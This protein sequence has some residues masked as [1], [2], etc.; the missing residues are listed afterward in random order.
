MLKFSI[1]IKHFLCLC[2]FLVTNC[3]LPQVLGNVQLNVSMDVHVVDDVIY[4]QCVEGWEP[5]HVMSSI[6]ASNGTWQPNPEELECQR[7]EYRGKGFFLLLIPR[8]KTILAMIISL[9]SID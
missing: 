5:A 3:S 1:E 8:T 7:E 4:Y 6:C 9:I 2:N